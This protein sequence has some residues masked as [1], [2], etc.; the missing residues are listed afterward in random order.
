MTITERPT[1]FSGPM[2][3]AILD[4]RKTRTRLYVR[5]GED[6]SAPEHLARR[7]ANGIDSA[8]DDG[9]WVWSR[10]RNRFG[11]GTLTI[12]GRAVYAHRLAFVL[13]G[14]SL[15]PGEHVVHSCDNPACINPH[16]LCA[17]SRSDNMQ[18]ASRKGRLRPSRVSKLGTEN[19]AAKLDQVVVRSIRRLLAKGWSQADVAERHGISQ[20]QVSN[21]ARSRHWKGVE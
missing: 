16:H 5:K 4:G 14:G 7:L 10:T 15:R 1:L 21:I 18:D 17:G 19:A 20:S 2:V 3:R 8:A 9:C 13:A 12:R 6:A 11:Y